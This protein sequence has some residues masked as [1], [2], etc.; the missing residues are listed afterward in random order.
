MFFTITN[1]MEDD[2][3]MEETPCDLTKPRIA[4]YKKYLETSSKYGNIGAI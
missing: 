1:P 2:N 4:P 3:G